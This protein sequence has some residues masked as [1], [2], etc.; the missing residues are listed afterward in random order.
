[1]AKIRQVRGT[2]SRQLGQTDENDVQVTKVRERRKQCLRQ[3][4]KGD[5]LQDSNYSRVEGKDKRWI[6]KILRM[7]N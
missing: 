3:Q 1:M 7:L 5:M 4:C 2:R 6:C